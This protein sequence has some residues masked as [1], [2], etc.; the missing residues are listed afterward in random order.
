MIKFIIIFYTQTNSIDDLCR[1]DE[2]LGDLDGVLS[3][4]QD[5]EDCDEVLRIVSG[6]DLS[7]KIQ[8]TFNNVGITSELMAVYLGDP[9]DSSTLD[10]FSSKHFPIEEAL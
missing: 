8:E 7:K 5:L 3:W 6:G 4:T 9:E 1:I 2:I 10:G